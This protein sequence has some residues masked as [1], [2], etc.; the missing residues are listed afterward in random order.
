MKKKT[1]FF[2][3]SS[4]IGMRNLML[5]PGGVFD[6]LKKDKENKIVVLISKKLRLKYKEYFDEQCAEKNVVLEIIE[7]D[8]QK[9][10]IQSVF[11][12]F[13]S[14]LVFTK[15]T[16]LLASKGARADKV[17]KGSTYAYPFKWL[18]YKLFG[19]F[20]WI[21]K[22]FVPKLYM[23]LFK[24]RPYLKLFDTYKPDLVFLPNI[25]HSPDLDL[26]AEARRRNI[27]NVG[28]VGSWDH[29]NKYFVPLRSDILLAWSNVIKEEAVKYEAYEESQIK[30]TGF[31]QFDP[32]VDRKNI[33]PRDEFLS[34]LNLPVNKK[35]IFFASEGA[36]CLDGPDIIDMMLKWIEE[37]SIAPSV[38]ILRLYPGVPKEEQTYAK[39]LDHPL[40][41]ID[42]TDN[43]SS[44]ENLMHFIN[45]L[46][47]C[48]VS[49]STYSTIAI[50]A[51][52]F[53]KP[54]I[55]I[56]F[57]GYH[58]REPHR[59]VKRL[60]N[61][62][63]FE[64]ITKAGGLSTVNS[65]EELLRVLKNYLDD[66][67]LYARERESLRERMCWKLDGQSS[68]RIVDYVLQY[69]NE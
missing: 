32:Y 9:T 65:E 58:K 14:Y 60:V 61:F 53:D 46:Y 23:L 22:V 1:I 66:G 59:S 20:R 2:S 41:H 63:H 31:P 7:K 29:F 11:T 48:D 4:R 38:I 24:K 21:K 49:I 33:I 30:L 52:I 56:S 8:F 17:A 57:D 19:R 51:S 34:Q 40:I 45:I 47:H 68:A 64:H 27:K 25:A 26:L 15:T 16:R 55:N 3:V 5:V 36:Y 42:E 50:E 12:F 43:W 35:V 44:T 67:H 6:L 10:F 28:M 18:N 69:L 54:L 39:Y 62:S 13:Y 37:G